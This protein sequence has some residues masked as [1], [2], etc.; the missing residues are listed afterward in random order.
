MDKNIFVEEFER[1]HSLKYFEIRIET[2]LKSKRFYYCR[3]HA[4]DKNKLC[5][6]HLGKIREEPCLRETQ[7]LILR[8]SAHIPGNP[9]LLYFLYFTYPRRLDVSRIANVPNQQIQRK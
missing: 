2:M 8:S 9:C 6:K 7:T 3:H 4:Y 1:I 5:Q